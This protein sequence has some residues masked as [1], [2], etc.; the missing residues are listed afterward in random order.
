MSITK[1]LKHSN[2]GAGANA[3]SKADKMQYVGSDTLAELVWSP[4]TGLTIKF[5]EEKPCY[6]AFYNSEN[7]L[8]EELVAS[9]ATCHMSDK[10]F[11]STGSQNHGA[12][13]QFYENLFK[14]GMTNDGD[15]SGYVSRSPLQTE[16]IM[17]CRPDQRVERTNAKMGTINIK[18]DG[19]F[20]DPFLENAQVAIFA[21]KSAEKIEAVS[22]VSMESCRSAKRKREGNIE[23]H[24]LILRSK[25]IKNQADD[26][27]FMNWISNTLKGIKKH[28]IYDGTRGFQRKHFGFQNVFRSLFSPETIKQFEKKSKETDLTKKYC[29]HGPLGFLEIKDKETVKH[30]RFYEQVTKE[31]PKDLFDTIMKLR[32]SRTDVQKWMNSLSSAAYSLDGFFVRVRVAKWK[33]GAGGSRYYVA[34]ITGSQGETPWKDLKQSIKVKVGDVECLVQSQHVSNCDFLEDEVVAWWRKTSKTGA[35]Q[36]LRDLKVKLAERR[37]R[38]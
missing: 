1:Q 34:C 11:S 25:R 22:H 29:S 38:N 15:G 35:I 23:Q 36:V 13:D 14:G 2:T 20:S 37:K 28:N 12:A 16:P 4:R 19:F 17:Q 3:N 31:A 10:V 26:N 6:M 8:N 5:V 9:V 24:E 33:E 30:V 21:N 27:S 18:K 32:L 7:T